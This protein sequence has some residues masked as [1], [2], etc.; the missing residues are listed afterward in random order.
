MA[1]ATRHGGLQ[2]FCL[3]C[4]HHTVL[5]YFR[6]GFHAAPREQPP[7]ALDAHADF[8]LARFLRHDANADVVHQELAA[9]LGI[10]DSVSR[11]KKMA[12]Q[13]TRKWTGSKGYIKVFDAAKK[14][15]GRSPRGFFAAVVMVIDHV[16]DVG[17][18]AG[19]RLLTI[20]ARRL[21]RN[22]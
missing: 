6:N 1:R 12:R 19:S 16:G 2:R 14:P 8:L 11:D 18:G 15:R 5:R 20:P 21:V 17:V 7:S 13:T 10:Q 4:S 22:R 9:E 3:G